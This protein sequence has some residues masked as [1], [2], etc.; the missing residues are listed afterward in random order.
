MNAPARTITPPEPSSAQLFLDAAAGLIEKRIVAIQSG[1]APLHALLELQLA[2]SAI[3][4]LA[5]ELNRIQDDRAIAGAGTSAQ[6][7]PGSDRRLGP[8]VLMRASRT[9]A[10]GTN[11]SGTLHS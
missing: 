3:R 7:V 5:S 2:S 8:P 9:A 1:T 10:P 6:P 11:A 4:K